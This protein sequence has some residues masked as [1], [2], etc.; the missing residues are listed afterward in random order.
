MGGSLGLSAERGNTC[1][2]L[3]TGFCFKDASCLLGGN[4]AFGENSGRRL[5]PLWCF[6][7]WRH[8][9]PNLAESWHGEYVALAEGNGAVSVGPRVG[10][11]SDLSSLT[12]LWGRSRREG[13]RVAETGGRPLLWGDRPGFAYYMLS[14][15]WWVPFPRASTFPES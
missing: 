3:N 11:E 12:G 4:S 8:Q 10:L 6:W 15:F 14:S 9:L 5:T 2:A 13:G 1:G 7:A